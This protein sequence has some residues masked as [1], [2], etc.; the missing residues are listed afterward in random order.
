[1]SGL[2]DILAGAGQVYGGYSEAEA[3]AQRLRQAR[4]AE[5]SAAMRVADERRLAD[6]N[7]R[8]S[9]G[10]QDYLPG[11]SQATT[12]Q[13]PGL[14]A[15]IPATPVDDEGNAMPTDMGTAVPVQTENRMGALEFMHRAALEA[16]LPD[17]A[18]KHRKTIDAF[19]SEGLADTAKVIL[20]GGTDDE[21]RDAFNRQGRVKFARVQRLPDSNKVIG[22]T[23]DGR[24]T[25]FDADSMDEALLDGKTRA[26]MRDKR[27]ERDYKRA[28]DDE[29]QALKGRETDALVDYRKAAADRLR[30]PPSDPK[31]PKPIDPAKERTERRRVV[32]EVARYAKDEATVTNEDGKAVVDRE[33]ANQI[34]GLAS[35][36]IDEDP[37]LLANPRAAAQAARAKLEDLQ[38]K[39]QAAASDEWSKA[40]KEPRPRWGTF[41]LF[42]NADPDPEDFEGM[43]RPDGTKEGKEAYIARRAQEVINK[44]MREAQAGGK[45]TDK[46][47]AAAPQ[48]G[49]PGSGLKF[50]GKYT[51][52]GGRIMQDAQGNKFV[53]D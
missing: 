47:A 32:S 36:M 15:V 29:N 41:G 5:E 6:Y 53:E 16:G 39:A 2:A 50:T 10:A 23:Q 35:L 48:R 49:A 34:A 1:M 24:T 40:A 12:V 30:R 14:D 45:V 25:T 51:K 26:S 38:A 31:P 4:L 44:L 46:P 13:T 42:T 9:T 19:R 20:A 43:A 27:E 22:T 11:G 3:A 28:R 52:S 21:I 37:D 8:V 7:Q 18:E 33:R 17:K